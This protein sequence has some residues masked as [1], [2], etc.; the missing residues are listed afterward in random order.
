MIQLL[1]FKMGCAGSKTKTEKIDKKRTG[2]LLFID[3][4]SQRLEVYV[5]AK[6]VEREKIESI[7][8][9]ENSLEKDL[10]ITNIPE[11][12]SEIDNY[13][14]EIL[15]IERT[16]EEILKIER[17]PEEILKIERFL[18]EEDS[19]DE[20]IPEELSRAEKKLRD[21]EKVVRENKENSFLP[22]SLLKL[23]PLEKYQQPFHDFL[24]SINQLSVDILLEDPSLSSEQELNCAFLASAESPTNSYMTSIENI[25]REINSPVI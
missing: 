23:E 17:T 8:S 15:K 25:L 22:T 11:K 4:P 19:K 13:L 3:K 20:K 9:P 24:N 7:E 10:K 21:S 14:E 1:I 12:R 16:P 18:V 2:D 5:P 6:P